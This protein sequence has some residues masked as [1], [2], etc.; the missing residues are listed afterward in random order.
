MYKPAG[1]KNVSALL[2]CSGRSQEAPK[3]GADN[4][5]GFELIPL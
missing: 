4:R 2:R 1:F 5:S 3:N